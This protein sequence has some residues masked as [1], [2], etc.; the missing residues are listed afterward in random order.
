MI[1]HYLKIAWRNLWKYKT[2]S[3]IG[4]VG[5][6]VCLLCFSIC[7]YVCRLMWATDQCLML[8][9]ERAYWRD[10]DEGTPRSERF[11]WSASG[12]DR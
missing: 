7:L 1:Q 11:G 10:C 8:P 3:A 12:T 9:S 6:A 4:I 2:Q 5:L